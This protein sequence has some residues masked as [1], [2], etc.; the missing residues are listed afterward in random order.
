VYAVVAHLL[1][2]AKIIK[3]N[4]IMNEIRLPKVVVP[5]RDGLIPNNCLELS[6]YR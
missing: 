4:A 2:D 5:N 6:L 1:S 3:P